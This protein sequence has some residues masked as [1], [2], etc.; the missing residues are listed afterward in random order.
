M[1]QPRQGIK[2]ESA[3]NIRGKLGHKNAISDIFFII[4]IFQI[5]KASDLP[6]DKRAML[7]GA[8]SRMKERVLWKWEAEDM[9]GKPENVML[10]KWI[11][12]Q[13]V[14]GKTRK[15]IPFG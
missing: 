13:D 12:Q 15:H 2:S 5:L 6:A 8:F 7:L 11:P 4:I 3:R 9:P 10:K 14:L 1:F